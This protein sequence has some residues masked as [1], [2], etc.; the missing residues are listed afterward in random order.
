[1]DTFDQNHIWHPYAK[2]PNSVKAHKVLSAEGVY[3]NLEDDKRVIDGMSSWWSTIHGY[4]HPTLNQALTT[5]LSKM[6]HVMFGGLTHDPAIELAKTLVDITP[7]N[8]SKV[9]FTDSGSVAVEA[10]LKMALQYWHNKSQ[11]K[12]HKFITIRGGYH[13]DT[14]GAMSVCD[15]DNGMH[16]LFSGVLPQH[17]FVKSPSMVSMDEALADLE[18]TLKAHS[19]NIAAMILEPVVQGAGGMRIYN[20]QYLTKAKA[21]CQQHQVLFIL[22]EIATG[23]GRT[24]ELFAL[25]YVDVEPDILC[26]GKALTGGYMTLAATLTTDEISQRVG[27]LMHGPTFMANPLA[28]SVANASIELLL[29]SPWQD[30]IAD[31]ETVLSGELS[32]LKSHDKVADVRILGA[33][34]VVELTQEI[35]VEKVQNQLIEH[36]VWLRPY[37]KL[38][39]TMPPFTISKQELLL[40]TKAIK[41]VIEEL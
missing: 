26:L 3:L 31:I 22:D 30:N 28:C 11:A 39:Y 32:S 23:F 1:M 14:F 21:L 37:G 4:N 18:I 10:A 33:I 35:D 41:I 25:E 7:E 5:Q 19:D 40:I 27:T 24:G 34:G 12:K 16:H 36:G 13:G 29:N 15:P 20:P 9:F 17:F 6:S 8:L 38:L 2:I